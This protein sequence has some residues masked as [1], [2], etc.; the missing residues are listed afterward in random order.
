MSELAISFEFFPPKSEAMEARLW[1]AIGQLAPLNP[2]FISV[3]Y[4]AGG[5]TRE[6]THRTVSRIIDETSLKP[7]AH[8]TCVDASR[9]Q[10]DEVLAQYWDAG[11]RHIVA[12]RGDPTAGVG[13]KF[14]PHADGYLNA[15]EVTAAARR[16]GD[17]DVSVSFYPETHPESPNLAFDL[18][19]LKAKIDAGA[20]RAISQFFCEADAYLRFRDAAT[21]AGI[22]IP[23]LPGIMAVGNVAGYTKMATSTGTSIPDWFAKSFEGL[24]ATP[25]VRD[26]VAA[27]VA[28]DLCLNL[29]KEGVKHF[30][31]YTLNKAALTL[32]TCRRLGLVPAMAETL[33]A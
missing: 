13:T 24:D 10:V 15:T 31:F 28:A 6:R 30:H 9:A 12:L 11:V 2:D 32:A 7:A 3:T 29:Q 27:S 16:V 4:G 22:N 17:F 8:L 5:S 18:D 19:V 33:P 14:E 20:T 21:K 25:D 26:L 23:L 1:D